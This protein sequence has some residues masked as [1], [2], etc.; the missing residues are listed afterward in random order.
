MLLSSSSRASPPS[1]ISYAARFP[2]PHGVGRSAF[3]GD[4]SE[5]P[6]KQPGESCFKPAKNQNETP[7]T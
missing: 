3:V 4:S 5:G 1:L 7:L 6:L 2:W